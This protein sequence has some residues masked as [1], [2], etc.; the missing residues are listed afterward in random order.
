MTPLENPAGN[1][2][3]ESV[4]SRERRL[5]LIESI[6]SFPGKLRELV[7]K[8]SP[9]QLDFKYRNWTARQIVHHIAD[10]HLNAY[11]RTKLALT[12]DRPTIK[13]Y[14]ESRWSALPDAVAMDVEVSLKL[15][16][17]LHTRWGMVWRNMSDQDFEKGYFP[18]ELGRTVGLGEVLGL[19]DW[20]ARHHA[21]MIDWIRSN[22]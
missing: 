13:P 8:L 14:N 5:G 11:V 4:L 19:Y 3:P 2:V 18:P 9:G 20:H 22:R 10:S 16:E 21:A 17:A 7:A 15:I 1:Y 12:E 6:E